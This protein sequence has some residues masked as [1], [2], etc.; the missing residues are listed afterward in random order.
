MLK[1]KDLKNEF[2]ET[3]DF[4]ISVHL[5]LHK[6]VF[7]LGLSY[8]ILEINGMVCIQSG[9]RRNTMQANSFTE[10]IKEKKEL[11]AGIPGLSQ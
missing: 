8:Q 9:T 3:F 1:N 2:K 4:C 7:Y 5:H 11:W 10:L 6:N